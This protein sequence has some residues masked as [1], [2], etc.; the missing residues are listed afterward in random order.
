MGHFL[1]ILGKLRAAIAIPVHSH[2]HD[3]FGYTL[4]I[5]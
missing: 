5:V 1:Q 4:T 3:Y 2:V